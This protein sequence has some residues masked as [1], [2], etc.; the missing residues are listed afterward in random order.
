MLKITPTRNKVFIFIQHYFYVVINHA[1]ILL[2]GTLIETLIVDE[3][4]KL[5]PLIKFMN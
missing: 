5:V 4:R 1:Q 2:F 3:L